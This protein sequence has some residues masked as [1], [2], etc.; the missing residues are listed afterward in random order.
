MNGWQVYALLAISLLLGAR[1]TLLGD[2]GS[3]FH[4]AQMK[5]QEPS[6]QHSR[7]HSQLTGIGMSHIHDFSP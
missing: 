1:Q 3:V 6:T 2:H 7:N 5:P 4:W